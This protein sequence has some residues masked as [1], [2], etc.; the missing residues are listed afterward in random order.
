[1]RGLRWLCVCCVIAGCGES[2]DGLAPMPACADGVDN[3]NDG[4]VDFPDDLGCADDTDDSEDSLPLPAC[5][6]HRDNDHD[7]KVDYPAD[8]GCVAPQQDDETDDC[9]SGPN[10]P[11]C[12]NGIDD[13]G[14]GAIDYPGDPGCTS[15]GD[16]D[17]FVDNPAACGAGMVIKNLPPS[18]T[19]TGMLVATSTSMFTSCGAITG[20]PAIAYALH[21]SDP[22]VVSVSTMGSAA[23]TVVD[24]RHVDCA[25]AAAEIACN[26]DVDAT[27]KTSKVVTSLAAGNYYII[28]QGFKPADLGAYAIKVEYFAGKARSARTPPCVAPAWSVGP[29]SAVR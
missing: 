19:D 1:M 7:G 29:R 20:A 8:P 24:I 23:N 10:C 6:D 25:N 17:E 5:S 9:P 13:D 27:N 14:N 15:A 18:S 12:A 28:V 2:H 26:D 3:D 16:G 22:K 11:Q 4:T 21:L